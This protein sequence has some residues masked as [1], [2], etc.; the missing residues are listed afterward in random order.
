MEKIQELVAVN[1][2]AK[3]KWQEPELIDLS[4]NRKRIQ[5]LCNTNGTGD[6]G[7]CVGTGLNAGER[8]DANG[9]TATGLC[10]I[11]GVGFIPKYAP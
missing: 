9:A 1:R 2:G 7:N 5:G 8:C 4:K 6:S 3:F 10:L 11:T